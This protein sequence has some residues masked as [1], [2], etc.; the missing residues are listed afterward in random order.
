MSSLRPG[1][2]LAGRFELLRPL[3][4]GGLAEVWVA[5][6]QTTST[7]VAVKALHEH[8]V[9]DA[10]LA[11]R[12]RRELAVTR[13]LSHPGIVRVFD[14]YEQV[15]PGTAPRPSATASWR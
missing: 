9:A 5:R 12:F 11:E 3:G 7:E 14:L 4:S 1:K 13:G 10:D 2:I 8:L 15:E 6:D